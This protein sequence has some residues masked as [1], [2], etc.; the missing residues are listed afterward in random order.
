M[1]IKTKK[2]KQLTKPQPAASTAKPSAPSSSKVLSI[3]RPQGRALSSTTGKVDLKATAHMGQETMT[4][5]D[6]AIPR[7]VILQDLSP[8][9]KK[10][11]EKFIEGAEPGDICD[12]VG[13]VLY[14]GEQGI[15]VAPVSYRR[16]Y[17]EWV[18][19]AKGGGFV[20]DHTPTNPASQRN[21]ENLIASCD[22]GEKGLMMTP[23]GNELRVSG[24]YF[25][26]NIDE[27]S[28]L[29]QPFV[30]TMGG[31]QTKKSRR[32]NSMIQ[33]LRID[34]NGESVN[35][36]MWYRTYRL[37][38]IPERNDQGSWF[39]WAIVGAEPILEL[40]N[41]IKMFNEALEFNKSVKGGKVSVAQP[42]E[43]DFETAMAGGESDDF[44][45]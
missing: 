32:W 3:K 11:N 26:F 23:K 16:S 29:Y 40:P 39:G 34:W 14:D 31:T 28:G 4:Q 43:P 2:R 7:L 18:P 19:R 5:Q 25:V 20:A 36:A 41:G 37:S 17:I 6:Y 38:T 12:V 1:A 44:P 35:P 33:Q 27:S 15:L 42:A 22:R 30:L 10:N 24:E 8:Q 9:V 21:L 13:L 45:M